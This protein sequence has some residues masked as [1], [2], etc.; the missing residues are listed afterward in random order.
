MCGFRPSASTLATWLSS[1]YSSAAYR[2]EE[3]QQKS[4]EMT[5]PYVVTALIK[6]PFLHGPT[7]SGADAAL[8]CSNGAAGRRQ[9]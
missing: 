3:E 6:I 8:R 4:F 5:P 2:E 9:R 1:Y 7:Q